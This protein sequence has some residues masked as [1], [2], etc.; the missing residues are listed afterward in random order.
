MKFDIGTVIAVAAVLL[1]YLRLILIQRKKAQKTAP[2]PKQHSKKGKNPITENP[3]PYITPQIE[4]TNGYWVGAG[5]L[6]TLGGVAVTLI[7]G[8]P[9]EVRSLWWLWVSLGVLM[10]SLGIH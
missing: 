8:I 10:M 2:Q 6:F 1:F 4:F 5:V 3:A 9:A 7:T